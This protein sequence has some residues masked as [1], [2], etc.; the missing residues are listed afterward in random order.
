MKTKQSKADRIVEL[1]R[2][3]EEAFAGQAHVYHFADAVLNKASIEHLVGS[4]VVMTL[5][6]L[7]GREICKPVLF[8]DGLSAETIK[9]IRADLVRSYELATQYKPKGAARPG[10]G[11]ENNRMDEGGVR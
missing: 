6:V 5:T 1:E 10:S 9:A 4:G 8:R 11:G 7:G 2:K 3:L